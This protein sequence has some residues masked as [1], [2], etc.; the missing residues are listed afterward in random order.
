MIDQGVKN[1][2]DLQLTAGSITGDEYRQRLA[3]ANVNR[4]VLDGGVRPSIEKISGQLKT[5]ELEGADLSRVD[6]RK[7]DLSGA[8]LA[9]AD[10]SRARLSKVRLVGADLAGCKLEGADLTGADLTGVNLCGANLTGAR[11]NEALLDGARL[12]QVKATDLSAVGCKWQKLQANGL[13][14]HGADLART[15]LSESILSGADLSDADFSDAKLNAVELDGANIQHASFQNAQLDKV[16]LAG[17]N[18]VEANLNLSALTDVDLSKA[19]LSH[20][21]ISNSFLERVK[22]TGADLTG[23]VFNVSEHREVDLSESQLNGSSFKSMTGYT[24]E[25]IA[26]LAARGAKVDKFY[27]RRFGRLM[28]RNHL[29]Q[30][31]AAVLLLA[32]AGG[33]IFYLR[34]PNNWS[35]EKLEQTAQECRNRSDFARAEELYRIVLKK[36]AANASKVASARNALGNLMLDTSRF[37]ESAKFFRSVMKDFPDQTGAVLLAE[38]GL[39][40]ILRQQRRFPEAEKALLDITQRYADHPQSIEAWDRLAALY[41]LT[42]QADKAREIY[43]KIIGQRALDENAV[44]RAQFDLAQMLHDERNYDQAIAKYREIIERFGGGQAGSRALSSII[45]IEVERNQLAK[46][47]QVLDELR[48]RYPTETDSILDG[49]LFFANALL[50]VRGREEEGLRRLRKVMADYPRTVSAIWAGKG[51][52]EYYKRLK[53]WA[54][55]EAIYQKLLTDFQDNLRFRHDLMTQLSELDVAR[56]RPDAAIQRLDQVLKESNEPDQVRA[57]LILY[58]QALA[59]RGDLDGARRAFHRLAERFPEDL[60]ARIAA[61]T[62]EARLMRDARQPAQAVQL[63]RKIFSLTD[64]PGPV[65]SA[66]GEI[67][68][69]YRETEDYAGEYLVLQEMLRRFQNDPQILPQTQL[70]LAENL[71]LQ[72]KPEDALKILRSVANIEAGSLPVDALNAMLAI[73][74]AQ[75]RMTEVAKVRDEIARRFPA[76]TRAMLNARLETAALLWRG[77]KYDESIA[78]YQAISQA[79]DPAFRMQSL[80]ALLQIY[81]ERRLFPQAEQVY[82]QLT[83]EFA[84]NRETINNANL[85]WASLLRFTGRGDQAIALYERLVREHKGFVQALWA[86]DGLAQYYLEVDQFEQAAQTY[87]RLLAD[88]AAARNP[89]ERLKAYLG[90]GSIAET[91]RRYDEALQNYREG[92][93]LASNEEQKFNAEQSIVR[94]LSAMGRLTEAEKALAQMR[95]AYP[96]RQEGLEQASFYVFD[97]MVKQN[98]VAEA[99]AGYERV[100]TGSRFKANRAAAFGFMAQVKIQLGRLAEAE[101]VY[102]RMRNTFAD[103]PQVTRIADLGIGAVLHQERKFPESLKV[104]QR[105]LD[106]FQDGDTRFQALSN[107][108]KI[109]EE[110]GRYD[111]AKQT[112]QRM[113]SELPNHANA[114]ATGLQ[115]L[116]DIAARDG[117]VDEAIALFKQVL[118]TRADDSIKVGALNAIAQL[119][120]Q[121]GKYDQ[122][123]QVF[124][125]L[126]QQYRADSDLAVNARLGEAETLRQN[127]NFEGAL[128]IYKKLAAE[129]R[130]PQLRLRVQ[131]AMARAFL[132]Q[133]RY[134]D[135]QRMFTA[136][137]NDQT[138]EA[139]LRVEAR[140]GLADL[141]RRQGDLDGAAATYGQVAA[142]A[143]DENMRQF[144]KNAI[145]QIR[146]EQ[147]RLD[148]AEKI[149]REMIR[150]HGDNVAFRVD[151]LMGL[152]D[153]LTKRNRFDDAIKIF[154]QVRQISTDSNHDLFAL[155]AIAQAYLAQKRYD[156]SIGAYREILAR[157]ADSRTA[158]IDAE[159]GI[160]NVLKEKRDN[161][162][163]LA[164]YQK[165]IKTYPDAL[166]VYWAL[167]GMAQIYTDTGRV[168]QAAATYAEIERRFPEYAQG[169]ADAQLNHAI[170]LRNAG[171]NQEAEAEY[172][173]VIAKFAG[174]RQ[175]ATALEGMAQM[176]LEMQDFNGARELYQRL[177]TTYK[178]DPEIAFNSQLG[179]GN[180]HA[181]RGEIDQAVG[182]YQQAY[183]LAR[184]NPQRVQAMGAMAAVQL[185]GN[186]PAKA[187]ELYQRM[188]RQFANDREA[189]AEAR[190]GLGNI[191]MMEN[192]Y[193][194]AR[195]LFRQ[196]ATDFARQPRASGALQSLASA[197]IALN[198]YAAMEEIIKRLMAEHADDPNAVIN[199]RMAAA[200]KLQADNK[201]DAALAQVQW[202]VARYPNSPQTAWAMHSQASIL[203]GQNKLDAARDVYNRIIKNFA[204]NGGAVIDA[205]YGLAEILRMQKQFDQALA[206]YQDLATRYPNYQQAINSLSS[207]AQIYN[208]R[209]QAQQEEEIYRRIIKTYRANTTAMLNATISLANLLA[210]QQRY[211]EALKQYNFIYQSY[212]SSDQAVWAKAGAARLYAAIGQRDKAVKLFEEIIR[213]YPADHEVVIGAR[214]FLQQLNESR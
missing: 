36:Y 197:E 83:T 82:K 14:L 116:A 9:L 24:E 142:Q 35:Y 114:Q 199:V 45:Q 151:A 188:M 137:V 65:F 179:L 148:E 105:L 47:Q 127:G 200:N 79:G 198:N 52:A 143:E 195:Q 11:L 86:L 124:A 152:G 70:I 19:N 135:A 95:Q 30:A 156:Q 91:R 17:A 161:E 25:Q 34:N 96:Q 158:R 77:G 29:A 37:D 186:R 203:I 10:L 132:D 185:Q 102:Q 165:V 28:A 145:A 98:R 133:N 206:A 126:G 39:T 125:Q 113:R 193:D 61:L 41:K 121:Q 103:D 89:D 62:G 59:A 136:I 92:L 44:I 107:I 177:A 56:G 169:L 18:A 94:S 210:S 138:A 176:R 42:G 146:I 73:Y 140:G 181:M 166:Q 115:G 134:V 8:R 214:Q 187:K 48:S 212:P 85:T 63:L 88:P 100:A 150:T 196:V 23:A 139:P 129:T 131:M 2:L 6:W 208:E 66:Y 64:Q 144:A 207:M 120:I 122:A 162:N 192:Q 190:M 159:L 204:M 189:M 123:R 16:N 67:T 173:K 72:D 182:V 128:A 155:T 40:D 78:E 55:A 209:R 90:L 58:A 60:D 4:P 167:A 69:L 171:R 49:E 109:Y 74:A 43:E 175:A 46:A 117:R 80:S 184:T 164:A 149:F 168:D 101:A 87:R 33:V 119:Y 97:T 13:V 110:T 57:A 178:N 174:S 51:I 106:S 211:D 180:I 26:G 153:V 118:T 130:D 213:T 21:D 71:R 32:I 5:G 112:Y 108:A 141:Q 68:R 93:K 191:A 205:R 50:N 81:A 38:I 201:L 3:E 172:K 104:Y 154:Q 202:V 12:H 111:L 157:H 183:N 194:Q 20:A 31:L 160:A 99:L 84:D 54:D 147:G 22:F 76:D 7:N 1:A 170:L 53:R 27:L 15:Q 163:A 75:D